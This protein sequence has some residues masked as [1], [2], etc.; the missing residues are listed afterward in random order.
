MDEL[1]IAETLDEAVAYLR[2]CDERGGSLTFE[3]EEY[4]FNVKS[5]PGAVRPKLSVLLSILASINEYSICIPT[6]ASIGEL[7]VSPE[8]FS[9][10]SRGF[11]NGSRELISSLAHR[12]YLRTIM[13]ITDRVKSVVKRRE[14]NPGLIES[15]STHIGT[16]EEAQGL[17]FKPAERS[18]TEHLMPYAPQLRFSSN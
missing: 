15:L 8:H 11:T 2:Q 16:I 1:P 13:E 12:E 3:L 14:Y 7:L 17:I 9:D 18:G 10:D 6:Y 4:A 5:G